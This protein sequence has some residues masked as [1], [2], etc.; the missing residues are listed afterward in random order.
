VTSGG[1]G[2]TGSVRVR[3]WGSAILV[4]LALGIGA[5]TEVWL[6]TVNAR[7]EEQ[8]TKE[9][10]TALAMA[11]LSPLEA[12]HAVVAFL[13]TPRE[14]LSLAEF[15]AFCR[16]ALD[17]H[18]EMVALE[19][20]P[21]VMG[22]Q[23]ETFEAWV[24]REQ[25]TFR[26]RE[27]QGE[28]MV[29]AKA[30]SSHLPLTYAEP[31]VDAV[32]GLDLTFEAVR[33]EPAWRALHSRQM[34]LSDRFRLVED[35]PDVYSV[36]AYAPVEHAAWVSEKALPFDP[37]DRG[38]AV[39]LFRLDNLVVSAL[40]R[41]NTEDIGLTLTDLDAPEAL[42]PL[43]STGPKPG[44]RVRRTT[45]PFLDRTYG[46]DV[47]FPAL[48]LLHSASVAAVLAALGLG[49]MALELLLTR[50]RASLLT[51]RL[52][53]LGQ[54]RLE[55]LIGSGGM[56]RVYRA[57]HAVLRRP[58]AIKIALPG[59]SIERFEREAQLHSSLSHPNTVTLYDYGRGEGGTFYVAMEYVLGYDLWALVQRS[60]RLPPARAAHILAQAAAALSEAHCAGLVHR[61]IKPSNIMI[62]ARGGLYDFVKV[63]DFGVA[64]PWG[65]AADET[66][67]TLSG[68]PVAFAG[69]PGYVAPEVVNGEPATDRS[70]IFSLGTVAYFLLEG[71]GPFAAPTSVGSLAR[72]LAGEVVPLS[73]DV[74][75]PL[76]D[77]VSQC[78]AYEPT[79]RPPTMAAL[80]QRL[81][82]LLPDLPPFGREEVE[83]W[84]REHPPGTGQALPT[85]AFSLLLGDRGLALA[86]DDTLPRRKTE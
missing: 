85:R 24:R 2:G 22:E 19:W 39:A 52:E 61:D 41:Q 23:R 20:F 33:A 73:A 31:V 28:T 48:P 86:S 11:L 74:P 30:R 53:S 62:T 77:L 32:M 56:G 27:L 50:R 44:M 82:A 4:V 17:R 81:L 65:A 38:V 10:G 7:R 66:A 49:L 47:Y 29:S 80:E 45:V 76:R 43:F 9:L 6:D 68:G 34:T 63:L 58:A 84:W 71:I 78:L 40:A 83:A 3:L 67:T 15:Q 26:L 18:A 55:A 59:S 8:R 37:F 13:E 54:Y 72:T 36:V 69:T 51:R 35:P 57:R 46:L 42:R 70:D 25:P 16:P 14:A 75:A 1:R 12:L 60:G 64:R 79:Q 5:T 21:L